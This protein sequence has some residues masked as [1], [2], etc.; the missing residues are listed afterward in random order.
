MQVV[1]LLSTSASPLG[2]FLPV[3]VGDGSN[4]P[5]GDNTWGGC[6]VLGGLPW[7]QTSLCRPGWHLP[8][9]DCFSLEAPSAGEQT[10]LVGSQQTASA[11]AVLQAGGFVLSTLCQGQEQ[12]LALYPVG[13]KVPPARGFPLNLLHWQID[14]A[15]SRWSLKRAGLAE[16]LLS[17]PCG[18]ASIS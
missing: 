1:E 4:S 6:E 10:S 14:P 18:Q 8:S 5:Y 9:G 13:T 16:I 11:P 2:S 17:H 7:D 15:P 12:P 3:T